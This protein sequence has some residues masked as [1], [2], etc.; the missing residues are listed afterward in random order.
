MAPEEA[1]GSGLASEQAVLQQVAA[2]PLRLDQHG[3]C[4]SRWVGLR[5]QWFRLGLSDKRSRLR[6]RRVSAL[7]RPGARNYFQGQR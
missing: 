4:M 2:V 3:S 6:P 1:M 7:L 5:Q